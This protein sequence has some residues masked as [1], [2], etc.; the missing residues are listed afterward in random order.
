MQIV[1]YLL[2]IPSKINNAVGK[3]TIRLFNIMTTKKR[4]AWNEYNGNS[5]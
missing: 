4:G 5:G 2:T 3:I 1:E